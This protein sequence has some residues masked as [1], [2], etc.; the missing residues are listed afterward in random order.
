MSNRS[1]PRRAHGFG[2]LEM[3]VALALASLM[4]AG[5]AAMTGRLLE[6]LRR[7]HTAGY[8]QRFTAAAANYLRANQAAL[9]AAAGSGTVAVTLAQLKAAGAGFVPAGFAAANPYGQTP[10]LLVR[11]SGQ[12]LSALAVSEGGAAIDDAALA[13]V[14]AHA[15]PGGGYIR[16]G[17]DAPGAP[18]GGAFGSWRLDAATLAGYTSRSCSGTAA[19]GGRLASAL[20]ADAGG[21]QAADFLYR[22]P[23][24]GRPE[25]N[26]MSAPLR[27]GAGAIVQNGAACGDAARIAID[28]DR[29][30]VTCSVEKTWKTSGSDTWRNPVA[31]F[32]ALLA[33]AGEPDGAVRVTLDTGRAFV[34]AG[35]AWKALAIDQ[36]GNLEVPGSLGAQTITASQHGVVGGDLVVGNDVQADSARVERGVQAESIDARG[37]IVAPVYEFEYIGPGSGTYGHAEPGQACHIFLTPLPNGV[38]PVAYPVGSQRPDRNGRTLVCVDQERVY[39]YQNG[40]LTP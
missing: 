17:A 26:Q 38:V 6:D 33:L 7:Q 24:P 27:M 2:L 4:A 12:A 36:D 11:R 37:W 30:I 34:H 39:K 32:G 8:Q 15:G 16:L 1:L 23:V 9:Y 13:Y 3:V 19:A 18:A 22:V 35:G 21:E 14:A 28:G 5:V 10:C 20:F 40:R 25:L 31:S 29:N